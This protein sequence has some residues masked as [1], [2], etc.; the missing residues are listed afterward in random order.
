[1]ADGTSEYDVAGA[2]ASHLWHMDRLSSE[3]TACALGQRPDGAG[4][5]EMCDFGRWLRDIAPA[6]EDAAHREICQRRHT[7][8]HVEANEALRGASSERPAVA[9]AAIA[10]DGRLTMA[11]KRLT[12]AMMT[13]WSS[14]VH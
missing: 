3:I 8:F 9:Q 13:W 7:E 10:S 5:I 12:A 1:M 4:P 2:I 6:G 11:S 14:K